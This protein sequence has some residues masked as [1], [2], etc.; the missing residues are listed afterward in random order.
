MLLFLWLLLSP[1]GG[2]PLEGGPS[3]LLPGSF[4][5]QRVAQQDLQGQEAFQTVA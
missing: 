1:W 4:Q 2:H 3:T 5:S